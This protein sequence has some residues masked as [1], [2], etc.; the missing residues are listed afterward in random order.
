[1]VRAKVFRLFLATLI[2]LPIGGLSGLV[3]V[4]AGDSSCYW[5]NYLSDSRSGSVG[6]G[7]SLTSYVS[8]K[9]GYDCNLNPH[10]LWIYYFRNT[11]S[12]T[13]GDSWVSHGTTSSY[14]C[15]YSDVAR[16]CLTPV[17]HSGTALWCKGSC[18]L[19]RAV[20]P[21][22][23]MNY[24]ANNF[25]FEHWVG[26]DVHGGA[27]CEIFHYINKHSMYIYASPTT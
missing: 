27:W 22:V 11:M 14:I 9:I 5:S 23:Y 15:T 19:E 17:W 21:K 25:L 12:I 6:F 16:D 1:M 10:Q 3:T 13:N 4:Q 20:Y 26:C 8:Y 24:D 7:N 2:A 18:Y